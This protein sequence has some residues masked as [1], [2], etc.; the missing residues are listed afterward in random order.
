MRGGN[1]LMGHHLRKMNAARASHWEL[2][3]E[4]GEPRSCANCG[5][6]FITKFGPSQIS[7]SAECSAAWRLGKDARRNFARQRANRLMVRLA[8]R[9][10][11]CQ[12]PIG[13]G[14]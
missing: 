1:R 11:G 3:P 7:C 4:V 10:Q 12:G 13:R 8:K 6:Q 9:C 5:V 2:A 14:N